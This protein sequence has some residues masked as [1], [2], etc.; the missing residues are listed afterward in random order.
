MNFETVIAEIR[1]RCPLFAGR[2]AGAAQFKGLDQTANLA[3]PCA[4]VMPLDD[5]PGQ[6]LSQSGYQQ[7]VQD[8]FAVVVVLSNEPD[9]RGQSSSAQIHNSFR[10]QL[11]RCLLG[12]EPAE[13]YDGVVYEG[14][15]L[16]KMDRARLFYQFDFSAGMRITADLTRLGA[17]A[18]A[19]PPFEGAD[20][21]LDF[22]QTDQPGQPG[23]HEP[24]GTIEFQINLDPPQT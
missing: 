8:S 15:S 14:G 9:E 13:D 23:S 10:A 22:I 3:L 19:L 2:V 21:G 24:D 17:D 18:E 1:A 6:Q 7:D 16:L 20:I 5:A 11:W 12:W 4:F